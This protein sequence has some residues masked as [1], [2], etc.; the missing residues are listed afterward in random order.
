MARDDEPAHQG[1]SCGSLG[2]ERL[3]R[4]WSRRSFLGFAA[5]GSWG[6]TFG[7]APGAGAAGA[8]QVWGLDPH[9]TVGRTCSCSG[10]S[11]CR[12]HA[13]NKLFATAAIADELR[14]HPGCKCLVVPLGEVDSAL[15]GALFAGGARHSVDRRY[16]WVQA[17][18]GSPPSPL[19][20]PLSDDGAP[21]GNDGAKDLLPELD[22]PTPG[23]PPARTPETRTL[24][25]AL[26]HRSA[27][28]VQLRSLRI[29]TGARHR[30]VLFA[31]IAS[32]LP[33]DAIVMLT[34]QRAPLVSRTIRL[35]GVKAVRLSIP[36]NLERV[37]MRLVIRFPDGH[38]STRSISRKVRVPASTRARSRRI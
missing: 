33:I 26:A 25:P 29:E 16:S 38:G 23:L 31:K 7:F 5:L 6:L 35:D 13:E 3:D 2:R 34:Q 22:F 28:K 14:A 1:A 12:S 8:V 18:F 11:A 21:D 15:Y 19:P 24:Q 32:S 10:C 27:V 30:N 20:D 9:S 17:A 4:T 37:P 36:K